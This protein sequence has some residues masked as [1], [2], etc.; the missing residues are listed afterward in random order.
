VSRAKFTAENILEILRACRL[1]ARLLE[2]MMALR[3]GGDRR[4]G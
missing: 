3:T 4:R 1:R 2:R